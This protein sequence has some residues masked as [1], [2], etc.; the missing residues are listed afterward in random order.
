M[1]RAAVLLLCILLLQGCAT[2]GG[3]AGGS[4]AGSKAM[5]YYPGTHNSGG[6]NRHGHDR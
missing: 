4:T 5:V 2:A 6:S 3:S 1:G